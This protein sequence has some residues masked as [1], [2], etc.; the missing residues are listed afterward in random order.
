MVRST[1]NCGRSRLG[2]SADNQ[3]WQACALATSA[4][5]GW[6]ISWA[7]D[8]ASSATV[9]SWEARDSLAWVDRS[10][11]SILLLS[12]MST[13]TPYQWTLP[14]STLRSGSPCNCNH[15]YPPTHPPHPDHPPHPPSV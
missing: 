5:R 9:A 13:C 15:P 3:R 7:M 2:G 11:S 10:A 1:L 6:L 12:S 14:P 4:A 8:A